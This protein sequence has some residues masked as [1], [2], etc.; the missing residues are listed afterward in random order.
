[1]AAQSEER[2]AGPQI[3]LQQLLSSTRP[4]SPALDYA[5]CSLHTQHINPGAC[6]HLAEAPDLTVSFE[7]E[8]QDLTAVGSGRGTPRERGREPGALPARDTALGQ[9]VHMGAEGLHSQR[10]RGCAKGG[11][12]RF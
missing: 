10:W 5:S 9:G 11:L 12:Q 1:M 2:A 8:D 4:C 7:E 3:P 6:L